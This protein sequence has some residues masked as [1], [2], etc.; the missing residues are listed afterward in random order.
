MTGINKTKKLNKS[1][2]FIDFPFNLLLD[3]DSASFSRESRKQ[4]V[5]E[6]V[7]VSLGSLKRFLLKFHFDTKLQKVRGLV[8]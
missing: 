1:F 3:L 5:S 6:R 8:F 4:K 2:F 7:K